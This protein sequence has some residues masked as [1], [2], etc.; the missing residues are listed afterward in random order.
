MTTYYVVVVS[1]PSFDLHDGF[2][3]APKSEWHGVGE[4]GG[5]TTILSQ[6][7]HWV[8][9]WKDLYTDDYEYKIVQIDESEL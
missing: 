5:I 2:I 3:P 4:Y 9:T 6:A 7:M 8:T 1:H